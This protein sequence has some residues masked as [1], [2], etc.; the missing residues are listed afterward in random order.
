MMKS[1]IIKLML[2][3]LLI[4]IL[5]IT[6]FV[7]IRDVVSAKTYDQVKREAEDSA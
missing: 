1:K 7:S 3:W 4:T 6:T 5:T 2:K